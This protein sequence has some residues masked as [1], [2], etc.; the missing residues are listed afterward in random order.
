VQRDNGAAF[1]WAVMGD[2]NASQIDSEPM[3]QRP[4]WGSTGVSPQ[5]LGVT[6]VSRLA[7]EADIQSKLGVGKRIVPIRSVRG[8]GKRDMVHNDAMP[9]IEVDPATFEVRADGRLLTCEPTEVV[10]LNRKYMLR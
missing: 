2:A 9:A 10:P 3:I 7:M 1:A 8:L 6:F 5:Q 4:M